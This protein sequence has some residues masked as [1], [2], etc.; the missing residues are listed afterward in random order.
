MRHQLE[1]LDGFKFYR[2]GKQ[3]IPMA[4]PKALLAEDA[5]H[6][7][8]DLSADGKQWFPAFYET[9]DKNE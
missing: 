6:F 8:M 3:G 4:L 2:I 9:E 1:S 5:F 7:G